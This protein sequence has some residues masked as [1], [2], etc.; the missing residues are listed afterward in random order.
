[1][2]VP[3]N[4]WW[5]VKMLLRLIHFLWFSYPCNQLKGLSQAGLTIHSS[6]RRFAAWLNSTVRRHAYVLRLHLQ[7]MIEITSYDPA[8]PAAFEAEADALR[9]ALDGLAVS[10]EH[11]GSTAI[12]GLAAK[13]V[14]DIQ[15]SVLS[16]QP[17]I[18]YLDALAP[19]D[20]THVPLGEFDLVYPYFEKPSTWPHSHHLH[21]C[22]VGSVEERAHLAFRDY[23]RTHPD[24][25]DRYVELKR[26]LAAQ[27][28]GVTLGSRERY[29]LSK[30]AFVDGVLA[31]ALSE[32][33]P[34]GSSGAGA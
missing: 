32:G 14:I 20:Y 12:P 1:M 13:P 17:M 9:Q 16:L 27:F 29:S 34:L 3:H 28:D 22:K 33:Y 19:L 10:I 26:R 7:V 18:Q 11:V 15:V 6:R 5:L 2:A 30:S 21:L 24:V 4:S 25:A 8:W 31:K 23:L